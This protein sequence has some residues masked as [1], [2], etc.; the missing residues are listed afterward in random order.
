MTGNSERSLPSFSRAQNHIFGLLVFSD[1]Q[2]EIKKKNVIYNDITK[3][4]AE[5]SHVR[6]AEPDMVR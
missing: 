1:P 3:R 6:G 4:R 5:N 2:S